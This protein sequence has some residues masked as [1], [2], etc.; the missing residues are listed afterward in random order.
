MLTPRVSQVIKKELISEDE[1][2]DWI[3]TEKHVFEM[4]SNYP[5]LVGLHSC[6]QVGVCTVYQ[7]QTYRF[8]CMVRIRRVCIGPSR[9]SARQYVTPLT[10][11]HSY[12]DG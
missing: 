10:Y 7:K 5:F 9:S 8:I 3:Q 2:I 4:A 11:S 12:F 1:D 6:F